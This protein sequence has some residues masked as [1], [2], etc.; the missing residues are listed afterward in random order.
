MLIDSQKLLPVT[1][2]LSQGPH[3]SSF[4]WFWTAWTG[5]CT[6]S[7]L[8]CLASCAPSCTGEGH[9]IVYVWLVFVH[10][11]CCVTVILNQVWLCS[12]TG[13]DSV[14]RHFLVVK[15]GVGGRSLLTIPECTGQSPTTKYQSCHGWDS[16]LYS[17]PLCAHTTTYL[18]THFLEPQLH[19]QEHWTAQPGLWNPWDHAYHSLIKIKKLQNRRCF[20]L[21]MN[22]R[23]KM[24][25]CV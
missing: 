23:V 22:V 4:A 3:Q 21:R 5:D 19:I 9:H 6:Y 15:L 25:Y 2:S 13:V 16:L 18:A 17:I 7:I 1:D 11:Q 14:W 10:S 12:S 24:S 8:P 20:A